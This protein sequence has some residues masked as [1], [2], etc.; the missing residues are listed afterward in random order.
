MS[1]TIDNVECPE[2]GGSARM[3]TDHKTNDSH[4]LCT[5]SDFQ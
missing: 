4:I 1:S 2:C 5:E 3:E